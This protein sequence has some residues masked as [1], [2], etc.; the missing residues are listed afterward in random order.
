MPTLHRFDGYRVFV[1]ANDHRPA[2]VHV[3]KA[4]NEAIFFLNCPSGPVSLRETIGFRASQLAAI[5]RELNP[6]APRLC[7]EWET[8]HGEP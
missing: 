4:E 5:E 6:L 7:A 8:I 3:V 2:H 1:P